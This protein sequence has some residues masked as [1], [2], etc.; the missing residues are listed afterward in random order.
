VLPELAEK[1]VP[2]NRLALR[3]RPSFSAFASG[4]I[5]VSPADAGPS[6]GVIAPSRSPI[7][8]RKKISHSSAKKLPQNIFKK[9][10]ARAMV[11]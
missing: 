3:V 1:L 2:G 5:E 10:L 4:G 11:I 8:I 7:F 9:R 6:F